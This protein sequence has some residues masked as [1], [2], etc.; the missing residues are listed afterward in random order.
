M[1]IGRPLLGQWTYDVRRLIDALGSPDRVRIA[2]FGPAGLVALCAAATDDRIKTVTTSDS[3]VS[4]IDDGPYE[5]QRLGTIAPG[6]L[7]DV[8]DIPHLAALVAPRPLA[9]AGGM[10][11]GNH[12][13]HGAPLHDAY[14]E[15]RKVYELLGATEG[16]RFF[17]EAV[18]SLRR[19]QPVR[20]R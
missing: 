5:G 9:I 16:L 12:P 15:T 17:G 7:R 4:Y 3:L 14:A 1:W 2:G 11:G 8:G 18:E 10:T 6:I 13:V 19:N 20:S